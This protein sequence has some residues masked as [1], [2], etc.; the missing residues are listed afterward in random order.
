M[1]TIMKNINKIKTLGLAAIAG[2]S[3]TSCDLD[4]LPMNEVVLENFWKEEADVNSVVN[5]CYV[6]MQEGGYVNKL[7]TWGELRSEN[8]TQGPDVPGDIQQLLK[9]N[10]LPT[11]SCCTW[12]AFYNVI[13]RCN[14]V[15]HY[16]PSVASQDPNYTSTDLE[17]SKAEVKALRA[18]SYFYLIRT[19]KDVPF[20]LDPSIDDFQ[21]YIIPA[22]KHEKILDSLIWD[23]EA[24]KDFAPQRYPD[25]RRNSG[26]VTR[27]M[28]YT[29]L[30]DMYLWKASDYNLPVGAQQEAY[31]KCIEYCDIVLDYKTS[32][33]QSNSEQD[34]YGDLKKKCN[35]ALYSMYGYPLL[36]EIDEES[37]R[38]IAYNDIFGTGNSFESIFELTYGSL[39]SDIKNTDLTYMYGGADPDKR[40]ITYVYGNENLI[41]TAITSTTGYTDE[42]LFPVSTDYRTQTSLHY[43]DG[44]SPDINKYVV[45]SLGSTDLGEIGDT[46]TP[47]TTKRL[48]VAY[49]EAGVNWIIY[50]LS[51]VMLMR[52][53]AEINLAGILNQTVEHTGGVPSTSRV[54]GSTL[55]TAEELYAD[56]FNLISAV[57]LRSNPD[58]MDR[59][60]KRPNF[61]SYLTYES[62]MNL[63]ENERRRE[64]LFEG[65]RYYD[66][67]RRSRREGN[68]EHY[69][70]A[71]TSKFGEA[72]K[73]VLIKMAMLDFIYMPYAELQIDV[74]PEL[75][76]N[77]AYATEDETVKN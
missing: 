13:N 77:P 68:T 45:R 16:A 43:N 32:V 67:V 73:A 54:K 65:K 63:L 36:S 2:L 50:R 15:L 76:Q 62:M 10:L 34:Q 25:K 71:L 6:G 18:L 48:P 42:T 53:E 8:V 70:Q 40:S 33:Y 38:P 5:S 56:A 52:A 35:K 44:T 58:A 21:N 37:K 46:W 1:E 74:N 49:K 47:T 27:T 4:L 7:I 29:L 24:C 22:T 75:K 14:T 57:Y 59:E 64:F 19:F 9:C 61:A 23:L 55:S 51:D 30:A 26:R 69:V 60:K 41:P 17:M 31:R 20:T 11:N 12:N 39:E 72:S 66:L 28:I 3:F